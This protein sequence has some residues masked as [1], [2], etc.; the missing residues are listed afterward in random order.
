MFD[1]RVRD[2][3]DAYTAFYDVGFDGFFIK[4]DQVVSTSQG[5]VVSFYSDD[6]ESTV[7]KMA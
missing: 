5:G 2:L 1:W 3:G 4:F 7:K 6:L